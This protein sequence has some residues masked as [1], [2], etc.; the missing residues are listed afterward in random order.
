MS[1]FAFLKPEFAPVYEHAHRAEVLA[2]SDPR[3]SC[4]YTRLALETAV[5]WMYQRDGTLR[6]SYDDALSALIHEGTFRTLV[7][8]ALVTKERLIKD[9]GNSAVHE[10]RTVSENTCSIPTPWTRCWRMS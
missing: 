7:G 9:F 6:T 5:K 2:L 8:N 4:F 3:G 10:S 1:Q